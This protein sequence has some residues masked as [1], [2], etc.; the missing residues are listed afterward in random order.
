MTAAADQEEEFLGAGLEA[1]NP[2]ARVLGRN[3]SRTADAARLLLDRGL[4]SQGDG[5][6]SHYRQN[7]LKAWVH[8]FW[9]KPEMHQSCAS[10]SIARAAIAPPMSAASQPN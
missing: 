7:T 2:G 8:E 4:M 1:E 10:G 3:E 6:G 5:D 9:R